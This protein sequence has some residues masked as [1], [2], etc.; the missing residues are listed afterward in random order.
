MTL[1]PPEVFE[2]VRKPTFFSRFFFERLMLTFT[3]NELSSREKGGGFQRTRVLPS[4]SDPREL[5]RST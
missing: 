2:R 5:S 1:R 3:V 4:S